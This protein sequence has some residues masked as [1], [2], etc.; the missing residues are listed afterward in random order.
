MGSFLAASEKLLRNRGFHVD[1]LGDAQNSVAG[2]RF[3]G[4]I[5]R[6]PR[7]PG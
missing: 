3:W 6:N 4:K 5:R 1:Y 7:N 2:T